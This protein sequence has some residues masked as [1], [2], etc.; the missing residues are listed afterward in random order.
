MA[1]TG[2]RG[3]VQLASDWLLAHVNDPYLDDS[4]PRD[5]ILYACPT[6]PFQQ[7]LEEF[8]AKSR[9]LCGWNGAH[10]YM[11]HITLV[12]FFKSPDDSAAKL[13]KSVVEFAQSNSSPTLQMELYISN[14]FMGFFVGEDD[15]NFL[16]RIAL[17]FVKEVSDSSKELR[18]INFSL[19]C[20][21]C[22]L[23]S[24]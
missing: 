13:S 3:S 16:K 10:N 24:P 14:N 23:R 21:D 4:T 20:S 12:S 2:N 22:W 17:Q 18:S 11:P 5:Y 15:A 19:L 6:G 8:W 1:A 9:E 7:K